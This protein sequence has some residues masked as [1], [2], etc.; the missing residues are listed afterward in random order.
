MSTAVDL[1]GTKTGGSSS[2]IAGAGVPVTVTDID[3]TGCSAA[4]G[5]ITNAPI[6]FGANANNCVVDGNRHIGGNAGATDNGTKQRHRQQQ[7]APLWSV[8]GRNGKWNSRSL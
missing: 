6:H 1:V 4:E 5:N 2:T 8:R 7:L 3:V